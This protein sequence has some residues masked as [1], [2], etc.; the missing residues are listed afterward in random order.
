MEAGPEARVG[1]RSTPEAQVG[2]R[3]TPEARVGDR[4]TTKAPAGERWTPGRL[5]P[6]LLLGVYFGFVITKSEVI[7][8]FRIQEMFRFQGFHMYGVLFSAVAVA[9]AS[10]ALLR[11][12]GA[13]SLAGEEIRV[14]ANQL[15]GRNYRYWIGGFCF[16]VGWGLLGACPGPIYA[17]IGNGLWV[18]VVALAAALAGTWTYGWLR[19]RLPH[20]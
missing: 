5:F 3:W 7:S 2:E 4:W 8:W 6:Y 9:A 19:P 10:V 17:L 18:F 1:G 16:G 12:V 20:Y 11:R 14:P 13:R 15:G